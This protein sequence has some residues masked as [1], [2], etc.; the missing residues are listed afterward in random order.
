DE[1]ARP[2]GDADA[3]L[4]CGETRPDVVHGTAEQGAAGRDEQGAGDAAGRGAAV[5]EEVAGAGPRR[6]RRGGRGY[7]ESHFVALGA[8]RRGAVS[9]KIRGDEKGVTP[10]GADMSPATASAWLTP[11][12]GR[13]LAV[14]HGRRSQG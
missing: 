6:G 4:F 1:P 14:R 2:V 13:R 11:K 8:R 10:P 7:T 9:G 3:Q 12:R 5:G